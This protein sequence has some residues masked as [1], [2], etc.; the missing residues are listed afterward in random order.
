MTYTQ[1][2]SSLVASTGPRIYVAC[3]ASYNS[4]RLHGTWIEADQGEDHIRDCVRAMLDASPEPSAEAW[5][6]HD[7]EGFEGLSIREY[8]SFGSV[9]AVAEFVSKHGELGVQLYEFY[10]SNLDD[11]STAFDHY[12]GE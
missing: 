2:P 9:C 7:Y 6:I 8:T 12:A 3:L 1:T 4:G 5:A 10:G 11:A